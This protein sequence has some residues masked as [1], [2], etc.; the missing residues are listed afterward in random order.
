[1]STVKRAIIF[2]WGDT[3]MK[4]F[5]QYKGPMVQ[6]PYVEAISGVKESLHKVYKNYICCVA[7]N[8]GDSDGELMQLALK[9]V[10]LDGY[11][12]AFFTSKELGVEKPSIKFFQEILKRLNVKPNEVIMV[13]NDYIKDIKPAKTVGMATILYSKAN[14]KEYKEFADYVINSMEQLDSIIFKFK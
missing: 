7:S 6:W 5:T 10:E 14:H 8:A 13:G 1:M 9:R 4:D 3:L 11:F 2:D 12:T